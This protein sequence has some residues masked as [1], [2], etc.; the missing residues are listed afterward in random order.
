MTIPCVEHN[1]I[2]TPNISLLLCL[3]ETRKIDISRYFGMP[4][5]GSWAGQALP[6][7]DNALPH[8]PPEPVSHPCLYPSPTQ[9]PVTEPLAHGSRAPFLPSPAPE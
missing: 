2:T 6:W 1:L 5:G 4:V 3:S 7:Q 9:Q 8:M